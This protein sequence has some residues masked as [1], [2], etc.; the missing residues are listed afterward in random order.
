[1]L[2]KLS[3][4]DIED[5]VV[6]VSP[7]IVFWGTTICVQRLFGFAKF[8]SGKWQISG[9]TGILAVSAS[10]YATQKICFDYV[11]PQLKKKPYEL[12]FR[13][14]RRSA[15]RAV[16]LTPCIYSILDLNLCQT[17]FP[18]SILTTGSYARGRNFSNWASMSVP[19]NSAKA[20]PKEKS[21]VTRLG[22][23]FG[24]HHCGNRQLWGW[25]SFIADHM[26]PTK[27]ANEMNEVF[28]RRWLGLT[29]KQALWPQCW[30]CFQKQ[31]SAVRTGDHLLVYSHRPKLHHMAVLLAMILQQYS[32]VGKA[33]DD[34]ELFLTTS[35]KRLE[36][37]FGVN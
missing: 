34:A 30:S 29:V 20:S 25:K 19:T 13:G 22:H 6:Y 11:Y 3:N 17:I 1:M 35:Y 2:S 32:L 12:Q 18:S 31:G 4:K 16:L 24:C 36:E 21:M 33:M 37:F 7:V 23:I 27:I 15:L 9:I 10:S 26:P 5:A 28:W 14:D 8:Y